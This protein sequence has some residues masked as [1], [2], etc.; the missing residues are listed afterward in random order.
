[1][2]DFTVFAIYD[3]LAGVYG[4]PFIAKNYALA[5]RRFDYIMS[6][7]S[8]VAKDC[9]LYSL[10]EYDVETGRIVGYDNPNFCCNYQE[11][12]PSI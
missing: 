9:T 11:V 1:M 10:A 6:N 8:M 12:D 7:S 2:K 3:R 4:D 5:K